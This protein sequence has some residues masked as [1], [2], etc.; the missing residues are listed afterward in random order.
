MIFDVDD[1]NSKKSN[2]AFWQAVIILEMGHV[3]GLGT[4]WAGKGCVAADCWAGAGSGAVH[5]YKCKAARRE[6]AA[7]GC[8]SELPLETDKAGSSCSHW[9]QPAP[10]PLIVSRAPLKTVTMYLLQRE[11]AQFRGHDAGEQHCLTP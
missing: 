7:L 9:S 1:F 11:G 6:Y 8:G 4:L 3:L 10:V 5:N 2:T